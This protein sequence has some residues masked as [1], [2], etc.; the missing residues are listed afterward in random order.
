[1]GNQRQ[2]LS[3]TLL[4]L[5]CI[6]LICSPGFGQDF[7]LWNFTIGG[8]VGFPQ[9]TS[10]QFVNN[11]ANFVVGGGRNLRQ[12]IGVDAEFMWHDL[13]IKRNVLDQLQVPGGGARIYAVTLNAIV[14]IPTPGKL[15]LYAIGGGGWYHR[16]GELT[17][18]TYTPGTVCPPFYVW[19]VG[20][21]TGLFP[22]NLVLASS[23]TDGWGGNI[24]GGITY[25]FGT[26]P[27]KLYTEVRYH[28]VPHR[29]V[30]TDLLPLTIGL[31]W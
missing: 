28:H 27:L 7:S 9:G 4:L 25:K 12:W 15:G 10:A 17:A 24:G 3:S 30:A 31:R 26:S 29:Q 14:P 16:S 1:M 22:S 19:W 11:G 6:G 20:C 8:G 5:A 18:P 13:P 23:S 21:T 2:R